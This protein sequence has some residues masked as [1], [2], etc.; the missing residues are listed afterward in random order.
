DANG[1]VPTPALGF[2][3]TITHLA[4][5]DCTGSA[6]PVITDTQ[7][8]DSYGKL[9]SSTD[10][11]SHTTRNRFDDTHQLI[12]VTDPLG[13]T[14]SY[15]YDTSG[16]RDSVTYPSIAAHPNATRKSTTVYNPVGEPKIL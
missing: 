16:N 8:Y 7:I 9:L 6:T 3:T 1:V 10:P 12:A 15:T 11:L 13:H 4:D 5:A 14:T 2:Q